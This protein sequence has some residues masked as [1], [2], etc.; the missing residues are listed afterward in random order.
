MAVE[1]PVAPHRVMTPLPEERARPVCSNRIALRRTAKPPDAAG[2]ADWLGGN[3]TCLT[4]CPGSRSGFGAAGCSP[5]MLCGRRSRP[6]ARR[7]TGMRGFGDALTG[8]TNV[9]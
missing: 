5:A 4:R 2:R 3:G 1:Q 6:Y 8:S 9:E 7:A